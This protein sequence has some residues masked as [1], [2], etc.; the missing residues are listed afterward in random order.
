MLSCLDV[1]S[2]K[3]IKIV[4]L[5]TCTCTLSLVQK[6]YSRMAT[7]T[8]KLIKNSERNGLEDNRQP[9]NGSK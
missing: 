2:D 1:R 9:S 8:N 5:G 3:S 4:F 7:S 6:L